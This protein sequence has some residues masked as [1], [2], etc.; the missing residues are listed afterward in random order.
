MLLVILLAM[1]NMLG[2]IAVRTATKLVLIAPL[3]IAENVQQQASTAK[4]LPAFVTC[5]D[6]P[7]AA[8]FLA[9]FHRSGWA[10]RMKDGSSKELAHAIEAA[11]CVVRSVSPTA[12]LAGT[13]PGGGEDFQSELESREEECG[14]FKALSKAEVDFSNDVAEPLF[15][16]GQ[17]FLEEVLHDFE[18]ELDDWAAGGPPPGGAGGGENPEDEEG[19]AP[20][21]TTKITESRKKRPCFY[22]VVTAVT[23]VAVAAVGAGIEE[24]LEKL[25]HML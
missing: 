15:A 25:I 10:E 13:K 4:K 12:L 11:M 5:A 23:S 18:S 20:E 8:Q 22:A 21:E 3:L 19:A 7:T 2:M 17:E 14:L 24:F 6:D 1:N 9:D 16:G